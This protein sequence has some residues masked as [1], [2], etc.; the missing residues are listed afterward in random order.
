[1]HIEVFKVIKNN[2]P[3]LNVVFDNFSKTEFR[4]FPIYVPTDH[5]LI[6]KKHQPTTTW[7]SQSYK[8]MLFVQMPPMGYCYSSTYTRY[9]G[10][11]KTTTYTFYEYWFYASIYTTYVVSNDFSE[12]KRKLNHKK[13]G[14]FLQMEICWA[15]LNWGIRAIGVRLKLS[16]AW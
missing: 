6:K 14:S 3:N 11:Y 13:F 12:E 4:K 10:A 7:D 5:I 16:F 2:V 15:I 9:S 1:M 8:F